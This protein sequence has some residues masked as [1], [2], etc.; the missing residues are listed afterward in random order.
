MPQRQAK[1]VQYDR[2]LMERA[3]KL[4]MAEKVFS[5]S[6]LVHAMQQEQYRERA[7]A[8]RAC[9]RVRKQAHDGRGVDHGEGYEMGCDDC[10]KAIGGKQA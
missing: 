3:T 1:V 9:Q 8:V 10:A 2:R 4:Y 7:R 6:D 5:C